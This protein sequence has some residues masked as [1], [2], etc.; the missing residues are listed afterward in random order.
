V[1]NTVYSIG[2]GRINQT[3]WTSAGNKF[4]VLLAAG[5]YTPSAAH[6]FVA[7]VVASE[8]TGVGYVRKLLATKT[9]AANGANIDYKAAASAWTLLTSSF[10][11][12]I[13]Y[14][15]VAGDDSSDATA[16]LIC[17]L[18][19]GAQSI[20]AALYTLNY[21]GANPGAVFSVQ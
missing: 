10:R 2:K 14:C 18:D 8:A 9:R 21:G 1:S 19:L 13:V 3:E 17:C 11:Y 15:D 6:Q 7:D 20:V 4:R 5:T 12:A 16:E